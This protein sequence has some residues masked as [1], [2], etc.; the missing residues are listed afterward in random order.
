MSKFEEV[1]RKISDRRNYIEPKYPRMDNWAVDRYEREDGMFASM[2]DSGYTRRVGKMVDGRVIW[3]VTDQYT[4]PLDFSGI[5]EEEFLS[6][7]V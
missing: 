1:Y 4:K 3:C 2:A 5:T 6:L 7:K